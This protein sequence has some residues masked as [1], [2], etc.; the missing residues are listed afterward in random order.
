[1]FLD[2]ELEK[3]LKESSSVS[4]NSAII[5]EWNLN[6]SDRIKQVGNYRYRPT[7]AQSQYKNITSEFDQDDREYAYTDA[8]DS[9]ITIDGGYSQDEGPVAFILDSC[10]I[11]I[12]KIPKVFS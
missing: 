2:P 3:H 9:D 5:A 8:T 11:Y 1:M 6:V 10:T 12:I 4:S 7:E